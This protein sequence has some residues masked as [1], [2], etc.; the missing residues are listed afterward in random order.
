MEIITVLFI[1]LFA[2]IFFKIFGLLFHTGMFLILL[3]LKILAVLFSALL[4]IFILIPLGI[5]GAIAG[6]FLA[7]FALLV[8]FLPVILIIWGIYLLVKN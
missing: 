8:V 6:V 3:P 2:L 7:P 1:V 4:V 5:V